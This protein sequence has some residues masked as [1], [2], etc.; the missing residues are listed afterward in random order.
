MFTLKKASIWTSGSK[1]WLNPQLSQKNM[2][3][4]KQEVCT[5][6]YCSFMSHYEM[7]TFVHSEFLDNI[8]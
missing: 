3:E 6:Q 2:V 7:Y 1:N 4:M 8:I 5:G